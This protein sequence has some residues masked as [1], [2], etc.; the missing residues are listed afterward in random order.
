MIHIY[1]EEEAPQPWRFKGQ[2]SYPTSELDYL[3][4]EHD[5]EG[6]VL[7]KHRLYEMRKV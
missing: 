7:Y 1:H 3:L 6:F 5:G 2:W 4:E